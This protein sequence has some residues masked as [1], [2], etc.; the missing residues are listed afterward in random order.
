[1]LT[2]RTET[3]VVNSPP[4]RWLQRCYEVS[5]VNLDPFHNHLNIH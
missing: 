1:M 3:G 2:N 4:R 5:P